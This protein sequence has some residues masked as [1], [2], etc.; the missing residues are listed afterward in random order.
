MI[1][2]SQCYFDFVLN[3]VLKMLVFNRELKLT[4]T[5][6]T[7]I[8]KQELFDIGIFCKTRAAISKTS[9][10]NIF[11]HFPHFLKFD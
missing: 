9:M 11:A 7:E 3:G 2:Y 1:N 5:I 4:T 6:Q 8:V 10:Q